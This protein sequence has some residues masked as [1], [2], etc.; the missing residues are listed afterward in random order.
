M[1]NTPPSKH[2]SLNNKLSYLF[3]ILSPLYKILFLPTPLYLTLKSFLTNRSFVVR[4][5][6]EYSNIHPI[7]PYTMISTFQRYLQLAL[8]NY[9]NFHKNVL[10]HPNPLVAELASKT[11]PD[12]PPRRLK[13]KWPRD[14]LT[15]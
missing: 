2:L 12:N 7:H 9:N 13:R 3:K 5:E 1:K 14:L 4:C 11:L 8:Y 6:E 15:N 10:N